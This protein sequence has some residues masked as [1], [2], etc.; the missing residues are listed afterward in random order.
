MNWRALCP[1]LCEYTAGSP[2]AGEGLAQP[3]PMFQCL[4]LGPGITHFLKCLLFARPWGTVRVAGTPFL[5][6]VSHY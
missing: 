1:A 3:G 4:S 6:L 5:L 2:Q